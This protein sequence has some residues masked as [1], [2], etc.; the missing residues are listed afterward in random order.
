MEFSYN[1][2]GNAAKNWSEDKSII[3]G[4]AWIDGGRGKKLKKRSTKQRNT[5]W[6][7]TDT[8]ETVRVLFGL[9]RKKTIEHHA[10]KREGERQ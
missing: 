4:A 3:I 8:S 2:G 5:G 6:N 10:Q 7:I 9:Q 1:N